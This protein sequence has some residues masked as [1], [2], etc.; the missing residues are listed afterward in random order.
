MDD[1]ERGYEFTVQQG[2]AIHGSQVGLEYV[3]EVKAA[4]DELYRRM[5]SYD[6][7][8]TTRMAQESLKGFLAEECAAGTANINAAVRG[9]GERFSVLHSHDLGSVD[10]ASVTNP[11]AAFQLKIYENPY[12]T[13]KALGTTLRDKYNT[14]GAAAKMSFDDW[15]MSVGRAGADPSDLLY[16]GQFGLVGSDKLD[17]CKAE[18]MKL[19]ERNRALGKQAE[20]TRWKKVANR[21]TDRVRG[22]SGAESRPMTVDDMRQ[23]AID[24]SGG[25][26]LDPASDHMTANDV[27]QLQNVLRQSLK[28]GA[29]AAALSAALKVAPE[30]YRAID[31]LISE[32]EIDEDSIKAIGAASLDG[33]VTGF[34]NGSATAAITAMAC[35]G[36]LGKAIMSAASKT[37][38]PAVI[39]TLVV[40]T[41]ESCKDAYL[42]A[43]GEKTQQELVGNLVQ[44]TFTS[45]AMLLG[46]GIASVVCPGAAL[47]MLVG[48]I[49]GSLAGGLAFSPAKS[50]Y[51]KIASETGLPLFGLVP[52]DAQLDEATAR[53]LGIK[54]ATFK[55]ARAVVA[56]PKAPVLPGPKLKIATAH[57]VSLSVNKAGLVSASLLDK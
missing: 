1:F 20:A 13:V 54:R 14:S 3:E 16:E 48:S 38:G 33:G 56:S 41:V 52:E 17:A 10:V 21:L 35:K 51:L 28:A 19:A 7:Y 26:K 47:P 23:K 49:V 5:N 50:C 57:T 27:V 44:S 2:V 11:N 29:T 25:K 45:A 18:A 4:I 55:A 30:I 31:Q 43:R 40:M 36:S 12:Q 6:H 42:V 22:E 53:N 37:M 15:A 9:S 24:V 34:V 8:R 32:G 39:G 46:A